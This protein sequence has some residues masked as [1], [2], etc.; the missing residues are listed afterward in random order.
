MIG[1][2]NS[3]DEYR[4]SL[5]ELDVALR[6]MISKPYFPKVMSLTTKSFL[7]SE[8]VLNSTPCTNFHY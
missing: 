4:D 1:C 6:E 2:L 7:V 5:E 8:T 3:Q